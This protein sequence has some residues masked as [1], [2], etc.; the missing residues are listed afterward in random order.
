MSAV[1]TASL[2]SRLFGSSQP[3]RINFAVT[4]VRARRPS[5]RRG[6][7]RSGRKRYRGGLS[8]GGRRADISNTVTAVGAVDESCRLS[9]RGNLNILSEA[10]IHAP[11]LISHQ[12]NGDPI[13]E[14]LC[15][16][17][18]SREVRR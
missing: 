18:V 5:S 4:W 17:L 3:K 9:S 1:A 8:S 14:E 13:E 6:A 11:E 10:R 7:Y 12:I 15:Q 16:S 2:S